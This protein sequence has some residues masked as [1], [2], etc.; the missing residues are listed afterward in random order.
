LKFNAAEATKVISRITTWS[1]IAILKHWFNSS[2]ILEGKQ[3]KVKKC[4]ESLTD[5]M[6]KSETIGTGL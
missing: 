4:L 3:G 5:S 2:A 6:V 1:D